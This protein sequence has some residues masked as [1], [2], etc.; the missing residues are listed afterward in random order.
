MVGESPR[1][2]HSANLISPGICPRSKLSAEMSNLEIPT[3][4]LRKRVSSKAVRESG[5]SRKKVADTPEEKEIDIS[6]IMAKIKKIAEARRR[7][8]EYAREDGRRVEKKP[9]MIMRVRYCACEEMAR[10]KYD[11][12]CSYCEHTQYPTYLVLE[13]T[14]EEARRP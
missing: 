2:C 4:G 14:E 8:E 6:D 1:N 9:R 5:Q 10:V 3:K 13:S 7:T 11:G 12:T